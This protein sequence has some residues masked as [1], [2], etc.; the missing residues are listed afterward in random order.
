MLISS[1]AGVARRGKAN[2]RKKQGQIV[3]NL[4]DPAGC[5]LSQS[6]PNARQKGS[7][8]GITGWMSFSYERQR[9]TDREWIGRVTS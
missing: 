5:F 8:I 3:Q 9:A 6:Y 2:E 7:K 1:A 4:V